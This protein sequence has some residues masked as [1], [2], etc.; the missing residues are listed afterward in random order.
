MSAAI[1]FEGLTKRFGTLTALD[2]FTAEVAPGRITAFLGANGSGKTTS[3]RL[4]LGL[5]APTSGSATLGGRHYRSIH[6]PMQ[7]VGAVIDQGFHPSRT[8]RNHLRIVTGQAGMPRGR[9]DAVLDL[10]GLTGA[11]DRRVGGYSLGMRQRLALAAALVGDPDV[12]V[13]D[14]PFNGLDPEGIATMRSFLRA[15]ADEGRTVFLSS[16]FLAEVAHSAD[17]AIIIDHGRLVTAGPVHELMPEAPAVMV[18]TKDADLL[19]VALS[20]RGAT[21][22]RHGPDQIAVGGVTREVIGRTA[23]DIG[24]VV[25]DMRTT[26]DDLETIF[27]TLTQAQPQPSET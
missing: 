13:L 25:L 14:E 20:H 11:A 23:L 26:G 12:L 1:A 2:R 16:H 17:D 5:D 24:A 7:V 6:R 27:A 3:M 18:S 21:V 9:T 19:A 15:F 10:V 22:H 4:L 8:A